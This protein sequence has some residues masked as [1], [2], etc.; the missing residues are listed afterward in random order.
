MKTSSFLSKRP[1][2]GR[3]QKEDVV[4]LVPEDVAPLLDAAGIDYVLIGAHGLSGW[5][6]QAR[7]TE[8]VDF[9]LRVRDRQKAA[10]VILKKYPELKIE[11]HLD[12]WR[13]NLESQTLVDLM[14]NRAPLYKRVF[15]EYV[16]IR[17]GRKMMKVPKLEAA[18]AMKFAAMTGY[19]RREIKSYY[20]AGDFAGMVKNNKVIDLDLLLQLGELHYPGGGAEALKYVED[21]RAGRRLEF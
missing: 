17:I 16:E 15:S 20:D 13:M 3:E 21:V 11:K 5:L 6:P 10:D 18:L 8:D 9:L 12:V 14:L 4:R 19:Y 2:L 7:A 1:M